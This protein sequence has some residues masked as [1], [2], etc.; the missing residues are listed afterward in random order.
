M[1]ERTKDFTIDRKEIAG[2]PY[3]LILAQVGSL[4]PA[5][6]VLTSQNTH[7]VQWMASNNVSMVTRKG[8]IVQSVGFEHDLYN[9]HIYGDDPLKNAPHKI[10]EDIIFSRFMQFKTPTA[11]SEN[12]NC[13]FKRIGE[14][15]I[16]IA[17][18]DFETLVFQEQ[19][20][21]TS[22]KWSFV[23]TY[24]IDPYDGYV[25]QSLQHISPEHDAVRI[26]VLQPE[27][28]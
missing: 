21:S 26:A 9:S 15:T 1:G 24:W 4:P 6:L 2:M 7:S 5:V 18:I 27:K 19:C 16:I 17:Q 28:E 20:A 12:L 22:T 14:E 13:T 3:A 25:W 23:N 8:R 10:N 11:H